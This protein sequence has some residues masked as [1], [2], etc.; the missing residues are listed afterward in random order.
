MIVFMY[1]EF[2]CVSNH[3]NTCFLYIYIYIYM[4][5]NQNVDKYILIPRHTI[6]NIYSS[7]FLFAYSLFANTHHHQ[8]S[9][10]I[11]NSI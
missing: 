6:S 9:N 5:S 4:Y 7:I 8:D 1:F 10:N 11:N 2:T 3:V